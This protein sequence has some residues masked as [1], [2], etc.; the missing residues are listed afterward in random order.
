MFRRV[1]L[2]SILASTVSAQQGI[3]GVPANQ[4]GTQVAGLSVTGAPNSVPP[5]INLTGALHIP[6]HLVSEPVTV[7]FALYSG[8]TEGTPLWTETQSIILD[9][10]GRFSTL[11]G[12]NSA[13]GLPPDLFAAGV[14]RWLGIRLQDGEEEPRIAVVSVPYAFHAGDADTLGGRN[15]AEFVTQEQLDSYLQRPALEPVGKPVRAVNLGGIQVADAFVSLAPNGPSFTSDAATGPPF[16]VASSAMVANLNVDLLHGLADSDFAKLNFSNQFSLAQSFGGGI[17]LPPISGNASTAGSSNSLVFEANGTVNSNAG[18]IQN[19]SWQAN[20]SSQNLPQ[21]QLSLY[22]GSGGQPPQPTGLALNSD[23]TITFSPNQ[24]WPGSVIWQ[25]IAPYAQTGGG[26]GNGNGGGTSGGVSQSPSGNQTINQPPGTSLN[27]NNLN[28]IRTVE[29][30]DN[31]V[32]TNLTTALTAAV[33]ATVTISPCPVGVDTS[34]SSSLGGPQGG[35]PVYITDGAQPN[36]NS[37]SLYV[38]G[39]NCTS[40]AMSGTIVFTPHFSHA[41]SGYTIGSAS[42]GIQEAINDACGVDPVITWQNA[43]CTIVI[44]PTGPQPGS[45]SGYNVYDTIYFH[46]NQSTLSGN[47]TILNCLGRG[48]CVQVG[49]LLNSNHYANNTIQGISFRNPINRQSDPAF[50]GSLIQSTQRIGGTITVQTAAPHNLRTGD[51]VTQMLTDTVNYWGDVPSIVVTDP[52]HY[53]YTRAGT[54]DLPLQ[55]GPGVVALTYEAVLDNGESSTLNDLQLANI[56]QAGA[57]N[58]FLDFWDDEN[59]QVSKINNNSSGMNHNLK[60]T[61][62]YIFSGGALNLPNKAQQLAPVITVNNSTITANSSN[63]ATVYNS[64]GFYFQNSVCQAQGPWEF[65]ISTVTGNYQGAS[66]LNVYSEAAIYMNPLSPAQSPWP[67]LGVAGLIAGPGGQSYTYSGTGGVAGVMPTVGTGS[68][69]YVYYVVARDLTA[70][71]QTSPLPFMYEQENSA[72]Q[73]LV[74]WPRLASGTDNIVYDVIRNP[75][76]AGTMA[77]V[78]GTYVAPY[79]GGCNGGNISACGSVAVAV[80]QCSGFVCSVQDNTANATSFYQISNG[81]FQPNPTFWPASAVLSSS[82]LM[83]DNSIP[84]VGMAFGGAPDEYATYCNDYGVNVSGGYTQCLGSPTTTNNAIMDQPATIL[85]DGGESGG[86]GVAGAKGR[87]IFETNPGSQALWHQVVTFYDSN[88]AKTQATTGHRPVGDPGDMYAGIDANNNL[89]I[90]G[91]ANGIAHYVNNIGDG[92]NWGELLTSTLKTFNVPVQAPTINLTNGIELNGSYGAP[93]QCIMS[94]GSGTFWGTPG[95][96]SA[97][98]LTASHEARVPVERDGVSDSGR[99]TQPTAIGTET[100][101]YFPLSFTENT[102]R[103]NSDNNLSICPRDSSCAPAGSSAPTG[104]EALSGSKSTD[105]EVKLICSRKNN[106]VE[107]ICRILP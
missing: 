64:N 13:Q 41:A 47:G 21:A 4:G 83:S 27:V 91:G 54:A 44:P 103:Q 65:L 31:W 25:A 33:Q 90:G 94:T 69:T 84:A 37:E 59:A 82:P 11:L 48:P 7:T 46:S 35:Y 6:G 87:L 23:G 72:S 97:A 24:Q 18:V 88:P 58:N 12:A 104:P 71:T 1:L 76:P 101:S 81:D 77:G 20:G 14:P 26:G 93:G 5:M 63:C 86:G 78:Q 62:S 95:Q 22:F 30:S 53:T 9:S 73:V 10:Q 85:T 60:W 34:G 96:T 75:A 49:D 38:T 2:L 3:N 67:G 98:M 19:F 80:S 92:V 61:S 39:G 36:T 43:G 70:G 105:L 32:A 45:T 107:L 15:A 68:T 40:G 57:F 74:Q 89:M 52:T 102:S 50:N 79:T 17:V 16:Q 99:V 106:H 28:N 51:R 29:A 42:S 55:A 100:H 56:E 8:E 66:F